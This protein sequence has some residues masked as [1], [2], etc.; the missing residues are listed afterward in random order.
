M[1]VIPL[2]KNQEKLIS[3]ALRQNR[4]AQQELFQL[5]SGKM[6]GLCRTYIKDVHQAEE[7]MLTGFFKVFSHL[8]EFKNEGSFEGWIRK[9]MV[10]EAISFLR[11]RK[12]VDFTEELYIKES[13]IDALESEMEVAH[14]QKLIDALPDGMRMV[15]GM[16]A[17]EGYKHKEIAKILKID[18]GTSKSQLFKARKI[19]KKQLQTENKAA[20]G[21]SRI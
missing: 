16:Y 4:K 18:I 20:Y 9:I 17:V 1:K 5:Y 10:R 3:R 7:V 19:L 6:L 13:G 12:K 8:S 15:F 2:F 21:T 14:I 11:K